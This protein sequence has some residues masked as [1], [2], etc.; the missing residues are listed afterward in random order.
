[1]A[2]RRGGADVPLPSFRRLTFTEAS[3]RLLE[4]LQ[5]NVGRVLD[6]L[7]GNAALNSHLVEDSGDGLRQGVSLSVGVVNTVPHGLDRTL[8]GWKLIE[9]T[10]NAVVWRDVTTTNPAPD[11]NLFLRCSA[12]TTVK[13]E[14]F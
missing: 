6:A 14:V 3:V 13:L 2:A 11:R 8:R 7:A 1:M 5:E 4:A 10:A 12:A 9:N